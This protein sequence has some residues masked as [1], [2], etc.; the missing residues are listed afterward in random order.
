MNEGEEIPKSFSVSIHNNLEVVRPTP[1]W[2][3]PCNVCHRTTLGDDADVQ[4]IGDEG[5]LWI[6]E[7]TGEEEHEEVWL[8][9]QHR[10]ELNK[11]ALTAYRKEDI[12]KDRTYVEPR[13]REIDIEWG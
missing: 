12:D 9:K 8:C 2:V 5:E 4:Y 10:E 11:P 3:P 13:M 6:N 1:L 7:C